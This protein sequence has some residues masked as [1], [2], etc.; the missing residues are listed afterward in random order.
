MYIHVHKKITY[1]YMFLKATSISLSV[2]S[3]YQFNNLVKKNDISALKYR[4]T[5]NNM[6]MV[7]KPSDH[8]SV[9]VIVCFLVT[10]LH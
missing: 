1:M 5:S 2:G 6:Y 8:Q 9:H 3:W 4:T 10:T 7:Y